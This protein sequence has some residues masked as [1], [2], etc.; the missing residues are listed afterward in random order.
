MTKLIKIKFMKVTIGQ[1]AFEMSS[2]RRFNTKRK[3]NLKLQGDSKKIA[4]D[5]RHH[6][7][8]RQT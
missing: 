3:E 2:T 4:D 7:M 6:L 5:F 1:E 8:Y